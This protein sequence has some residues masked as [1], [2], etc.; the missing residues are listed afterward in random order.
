[1]ADFN[2]V[3][4]PGDYKNGRLNTV[5]EIPEGSFLK[6]EW[7]SQRAAFML[8]RVEPSVYA[9]PVNYGFIPQT[10]DDDG[11]ELDTLVVCDEPIPT[12]VWLE[13]K[14][15]GIM[16]FEDGGDMDHKIVVVPAD[17]RNTGD[18]IN[19]LNDLGERWKQK[20]S[21]HFTHY[22]DLK[23]PGTTKVLGWGDTEAAKQVIAESIARYK[24]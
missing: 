24:K 2:Q 8:D 23:K 16:N 11:D 9:K 5:V 7:D 4:D 12:G 22:K 20:I 19:S 21:D 6:I 17:D 13:G 3:L 14:I 18:S 15:I 10:L 1:M